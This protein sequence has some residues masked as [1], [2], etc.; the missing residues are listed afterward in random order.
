M[1]DLSPLLEIL[2]EVFCKT[3]GEKKGGVGKIGFE[4]EKSSEG[5]RMF[6]EF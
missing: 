1:I 2:F 4:K 3:K 5:W 6:F